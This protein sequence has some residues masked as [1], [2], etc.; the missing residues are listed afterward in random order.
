VQRAKCTD[1]TKAINCVTPK[2]LS[3]A[4]SNN[5][6]ATILIGIGGC[7]VSY[8]GFT[9]KA[10]EKWANVAAGCLLAGIGLMTWQS[11]RRRL[12]L[13][14]VASPPGSPVTEVDPAFNPD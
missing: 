5:V 11:V 3:N 1:W 6:V 14:I 8:A 9:G 10:A 12:S 2:A 4:E 13:R 7:L